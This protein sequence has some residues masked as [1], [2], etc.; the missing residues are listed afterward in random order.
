MRNRLFVLALA[1]AAGCGGGGAGKIM[2]DTPAMP[3]QPLDA[4]GKPSGRAVTVHSDQD[5]RFTAYLPTTGGGGGA[6]RYRLVLRV[7]PPS[8]DDMPA[9]FRIQGAAMKTV[10]L[11]RHLADGQTLNLLVTQ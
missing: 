6:S 11:A 1:L 10:T 7:D 3:F 9:P 4:D 2:A 8:D 5:G